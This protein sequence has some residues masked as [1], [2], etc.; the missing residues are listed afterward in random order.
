MFLLV[1]LIHNSMKMKD[2]FKA[3]NLNDPTFPPQVKEKT[4]LCLKRKE[5]L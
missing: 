4:Q 5:K 3:Q 2:I 1:L